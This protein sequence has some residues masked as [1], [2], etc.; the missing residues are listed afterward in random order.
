MLIPQNKYLQPGRRK[1][2]IA[3]VLSLGPVSTKVIGVVLL[4]LLALFYLAQSTQSATNNYAIQN[5][6]DRRTNLE[7]SKDELAAEAMRLKSLESISAKAQEL[8]LEP[9]Q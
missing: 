1:R 6:Q 9:E 4:A 7:A 8:K 2:T 3:Q 5:L